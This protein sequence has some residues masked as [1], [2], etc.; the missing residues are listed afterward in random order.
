MSV[1]LAVALA[2]TVAVT[3][4]MVV[5]VAVATRVAGF[6]WQPPSFYPSLSCLRYQGPMSRDLFHAI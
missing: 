4:A 2:V 1:T 5:V 3:V 6:P